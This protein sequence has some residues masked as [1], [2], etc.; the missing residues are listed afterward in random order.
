MTPGKR[1]RESALSGGNV[2]TVVRVGEYV[3]RAVG[4]RSSTVHDLLRYLEARGFDGAPRFLGFDDLGREVLTFIEGEVGSYPLPSY[5]WSDQALTKAARL[6]RRYHDATTGY[7]PPEGAL[8]QLDAPHPHEVICHNDFAPYN[9]VFVSGEP[10]AIIDF[11]TAGPGPRI[12]DV[13]YA[14]YR[15][16]PLSND[17]HIQTLGLTRPPA[18]GKRLRMFCDAYGLEQDRRREL[19][20][21]VERRLE[22][23]CEFI[24][25]SAASGDASYEKAV[26]AGHVDLYRRDIESLRRRRTE[27]QETLL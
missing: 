1:E 9:V 6:L 7:E 26:E 20:E 16:V 17:E 11:D 13:A 14:V 2:T 3:H 21:T 24:V 8:W 15:F 19:L 23:L 27:L 18:R 22:A 12:W 10:R 5:M 25:S 4:P